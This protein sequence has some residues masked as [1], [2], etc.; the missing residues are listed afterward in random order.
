MDKS[1]RSIKGVVDNKQ[2]GARPKLVLNIETVANTTVLE[3]T[4]ARKTVDPIEQIA[5]FLYKYEVVDV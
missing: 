1:W 3:E 4:L 5:L 2:G